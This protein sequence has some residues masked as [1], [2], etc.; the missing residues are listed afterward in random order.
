MRAKKGLY[1]S[2]VVPVLHGGVLRLKSVERKK[3]NV[4][5]LNCFRNMCGVTRRDLVCN[6]VVRWRV[7]VDRKLSN[8]V[9]ERVSS[10]FGHVERM[11]D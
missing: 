1:E 2:I 3:L 5:E 11:S 10:W 8:R 7:G 4:M 6:E 9:D